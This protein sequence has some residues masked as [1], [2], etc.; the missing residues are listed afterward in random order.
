MKEPCVPIVCMDGP[1]KGRTYYFPASTQEFQLNTLVPGSAEAVYYGAPLSGYAGFIHRVYM[2]W[3]ANAPPYGAYIE[4]VTTGDNQ[5][6]EW[7][8]FRRC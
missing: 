5:V 8:G 4:R 2:M 7:R 3:G 6:H 1:R